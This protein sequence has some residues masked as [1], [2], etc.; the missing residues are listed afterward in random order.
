VKVLITGGLGFLGS[1]L[2]DLLLSEGY[3][4]IIIDDK[5]SNTVDSI[6]KCDVYDFSIETFAEY[7]SRFSDVDIVFHLASVVGPFGV[8]RHAGNMGYSILRDTKI[9]RDFCVLRNIPMIDIS[10][11]EVYGHPGLL[12][13]DSLK[14]I[15]GKYQIRNEYGGAKIVAEMSLVNFARLNQDFKYQIIRPFNI[16]GPRQKPDGGF[17]LPRF[18]VSAL[19]GQPITIFEDGMQERAFTDVRDVV[20]AIYLIS[21]SKKSNNIWNVGNEKN[22]MTI[23]ALA[24]MVRERAS[25]LVP[26]IN[27]PEINFYDPKEIHGSLFAKAIDK[28]PQIDKLLANTAWKP[29]FTLKQTIDDTILYYADKINNQNYYFDVMR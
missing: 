16:A 3:Q 18:V 13:E 5:T 21:Q 6:S 23:R 24:E 20:S 9:I 8:L 11:S 15:A 27:F 1:H 2:A 26:E 22:R 7:P 17:V 12:L 10:T 19:T 4:V 28:I 25:I 14:V 29:Q